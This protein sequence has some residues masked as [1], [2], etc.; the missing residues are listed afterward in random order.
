MNIR[1]AAIL[2]K[3][4]CARENC[5]RSHIVVDG[6]EGGRTG[7][8]KAWQSVYLRVRRAVGSKKQQ[9]MERRKVSSLDCNCFL[10]ES[11]F[12]EDS[13]ALTL[14]RSTMAPQG[15]ENFNQR[16]GGRGQSLSSSY[17]APDYAV[18]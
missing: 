7:R 15:G 12:A 17:F 5:E 9:R 10:P 6:G 4:F 3:L 13:L 16:A 18:N 1:M 14:P 11:R 8:R 2:I